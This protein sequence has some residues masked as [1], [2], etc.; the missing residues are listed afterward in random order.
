MGKSLRRGFKMKQIIYL[1]VS[2]LCARGILYL[3]NKLTLD[4]V[5]QRVI[6]AYMLAIL[7]V[8]IYGILNHKKLRG[9]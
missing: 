4:L 3:L 6:F 9:T 8:M 2:V 5:Y 1:M 7:S